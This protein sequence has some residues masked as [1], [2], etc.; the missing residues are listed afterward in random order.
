MKET[1]HLGKRF[2]AVYGWTKI[3]PAAFV[4]AL[5]MKL[6]LQRLLLHIV[7]PHFIHEHHTVQCILYAVLWLVS[8][9]T[10]S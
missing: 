7:G 4:F 6:R 3:V 8:V 2:W 1:S 10:S 9:L 5:S